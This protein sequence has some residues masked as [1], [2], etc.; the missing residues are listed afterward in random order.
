MFDSRE[1]IKYFFKKKW[2]P[3][4]SGFNE[5]RDFNKYENGISGQTV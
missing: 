3:P 5:A 4:N 1:L 2:Y